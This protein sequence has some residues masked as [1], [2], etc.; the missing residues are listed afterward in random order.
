M[1]TSV[2]RRGRDLPSEKSQF[3]AG[4]V[5]LPAELDD[6]AMCRAHVDTRVADGDEMRS[7]PT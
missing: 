1:D 7:G 2:R 4:H 6:H 5:R 3:A